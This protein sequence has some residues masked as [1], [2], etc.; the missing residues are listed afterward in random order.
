MFYNILDSGDDY[1]DFVANTTDC[2]TNQ[3]IQDATGC[4]G[5]DA[6]LTIL[7]DGN[8]EI[9]ILHAV[10]FDV[11]AAGA[12]A[13]LSTTSLSF[14]STAVGQTSV[15][16]VT[17]TN[18]GGGA[19]NLTGIS[20]SGIDPTN[21]SHTSN[22]GGNPLAP[23]SYCTVEVSF[24]PATAGSF[25]ATLNIN[26]NGSGAPQAVTLSG[27]G[28]NPPSV[29]LSPRSLSFPAAAVGATSTLPFTITDSGNSTLNVTV[30]SKC[31]SN[32][33]DFSHTSNCGGNPLAPGSSCTAEVSFA[34]ASNE[35]F[36][37]TLS[38]TDNATGSP[39][40]VTLSGV[41]AVP[42][43]MTLSP[44]SL[45]FGEVGTGETVT[46]NVQ[47][48]NTGGSNLVVTLIST[49]GPFTHL[50]GFGSESCSGGVQI[51]PGNS[52][53]IYVSFYGGPVGVNT[54][55]LFI[56]DNATGSPQQVPLSATVVQVCCGE[57][58]KSK[59]N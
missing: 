24:T 34:P 53:D 12:A 16:P 6:G 29:S 20:N 50:V 10:G 23:G 9:A 32:P 47:V 25:S 40:A 21:F 28:A 59:A 15:L 46:G 43:G 5:E 4:P 55:T 22:C 57:P 30:I 45:N 26:D 11:A 19:L 3:A 41:G 33:T 18:T 31:G 1:A 48:T 44:T 51:A 49:S 7:N 8:G 37:A 27:T 36:S 2:G 14:S 35:A 54:G 38:I 42:A 13:Q 58:N 39:Q 17:I 56:T 52:C